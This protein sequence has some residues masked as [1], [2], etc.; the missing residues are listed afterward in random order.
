MLNGI[1][2]MELL[3]AKIVTNEWE[4]KLFSRKCCNL[5]VAS[6]EPI[7]QVFQTVCTHKSTESFDF[8]S[9][10]VPS[11]VTPELIDCLQEVGFRFIECYQRYTRTKVEGYSHH[12]VREARPEEAEEIASIAVQVLNNSRYHNDSRFTRTLADKTRVQW[13]MDAFD[14]KEKTVFVCDNPDAKI[15]NGFLIGK[16]MLGRV[17]I[18][19]LGVR[20][21]EA[22]SGVGTKLVESFHYH[23]FFQE[24]SKTSCF[25]VGT[26]ATN[27]R[28]ISFYN[29]MGYVLDLT[30]YTFHLHI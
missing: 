1:K 5:I 3:M 22:R 26:Q 13:V 10:K 8:L 29:K 12:E 24:D 4:S 21:K 23:Y 18:D 30:S 17:V 19:L 11:P 16:Q 27:V 6:N 14:S 9:V 25:L 2:Q 28:A 20:P 7:E 15:I